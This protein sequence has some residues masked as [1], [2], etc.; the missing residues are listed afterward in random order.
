MWMAT[1]AMSPTCRRHDTT[2]LAPA[3]SPSHARSVR[4]DIYPPA[5]GPKETAQVSI[6]MRGMFTR[7]RYCRSSP[8]PEDMSP[9]APGHGRFMS[10]RLR[11][12]PT[13][14]ILK[15]R[16]STL[17]AACCLPTQEA[18]A[19][20]NVNQLVL[21]SSDHQDVRNNEPRR[22]HICAAE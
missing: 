10:V 2:P 14:I 20:E 18:H 17:N 11:R 1:G 6:S 12:R 15:P 8:P 5:D 3:A 7:R 4:A 21:S 22:R 16:R 19:R 13:R 9:H